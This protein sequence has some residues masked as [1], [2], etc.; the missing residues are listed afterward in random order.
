[1]PKTLAVGDV[2]STMREAGGELLKNVSVFDVFEGGNL[3]PGQKSVSF[4]LRF[5]DKASTLQDE[6]VLG[7]M[8]QVLDSVKQKWGLATR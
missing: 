6:A 2:M 3:E 8:T 7:R 1:M 4:R 5:Q